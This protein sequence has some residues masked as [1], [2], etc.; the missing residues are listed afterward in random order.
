MEDRPENLH[1]ILAWCHR[2]RA[3]PEIK[4]S[5]SVGVKIQKFSETTRQK[6]MDQEPW[7]SSF[8]D[9]E[10]KQMEEIILFFKS[11]ENQTISENL[12]NS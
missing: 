10:I 9:L 7:E 1:K 12:K 6:L 5:P 4:G 11:L 8:L 2:V 3:L